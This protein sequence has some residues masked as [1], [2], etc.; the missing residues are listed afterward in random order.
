M[1]IEQTK[2]KATVCKYHN[3]ER[4]KKTE[5]KQFNVQMYE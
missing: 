5:T 4:Q 3:V 2:N 1:L